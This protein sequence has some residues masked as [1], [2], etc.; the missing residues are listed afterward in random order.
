LCAV[1]RD[2]PLSWPRHPESPLSSRRSAGGAGH[3]MVRSESDC[4]GVS[5]CRFL[6]F[7]PSRG[8]PN[9]PNQNPSQRRSARLDGSPVLSHPGCLRTMLPL[10]WT[11]LLWDEM[12]DRTRKRRGK[13]PERALTEEVA[14]YFRIPGRYGD[15]NGLYLV[16]SSTGAKRWVQRIVVDGRRRDLGLGG[17]PLVSLEEAR[18]KALAYR[19]ATRARGQ[20][21]L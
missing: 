3:Q 15:G 21:A 6:G 18:A 16:V 9:L 13:H 4:L 5:S 20:D 12:W 10:S 8:S 11:K 1:H 19:K 7:R 14:D 17:F 2:T